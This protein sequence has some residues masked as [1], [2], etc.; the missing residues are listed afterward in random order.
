MIV[1]GLSRAQRIFLR[2]YLHQISRVSFNRVLTWVVI[3][4]PVSSV[5]YYAPCPLHSTPR[6]QSTLDTMLST[7]SLRGTP[8]ALC[9]ITIT[10]LIFKD[11]IEIN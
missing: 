7:S 9:K 10:G 6:Y 2:L 11:G 3:I 4:Q 8:H 1:F 5:H